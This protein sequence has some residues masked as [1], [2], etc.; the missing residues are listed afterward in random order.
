MAAVPP[1]SGLRKVTYALHWTRLSC[2]RFVSNQV[3]LGLFVLAYNLGNFLRRLVLP[4]K[5]N[6][7]PLRSLLVKLIKISTFTGAGSRH[8]LELSGKRLLTQASNSQ[9][10]GVVRRPDA[11]L[12][13]CS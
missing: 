1:S 10:S 3:R 9:A 2:K 7:G 11:K 8:R 13:R 12:V 5:I 4:R 6:T